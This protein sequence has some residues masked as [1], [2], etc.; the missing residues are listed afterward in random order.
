MEE[1]HYKP[2][3]A[4]FE[5]DGKAERWAQ[6]LKLGNK[7]YYDL[8]VIRSLLDST[9]LSVLRH[10]YHYRSER[11]GE[12]W[13]TRGRCKEMLADH[14]HTHYWRGAYSDTS[15]FDTEGIAALKASMEEGKAL[16]LWT[17]HSAE[18]GRPVPFP[19]KEGEV[20]VNPE[21][22]AWL[23][24]VFYGD[25]FDL[26]QNSRVSTEHPSWREVYLGGQAEG[27]PQIW[28]GIH[29]GELEVL[30]GEGLLVRPAGIVVDPYKVFAE[31]L[32]A[33]DA[34]TGTRYHACATMLPDVYPD[35]WE[36][37]RYDTAK[38]EAMANEL[39]KAEST[40]RSALNDLRCKRKES[41]AFKDI[42]GCDGI[43][44]AIGKDIAEG[45][46]ER[47]PLW[48]AAVPKGRRGRSDEQEVMLA[49]A[50]RYL[51]GDLKLPE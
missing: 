21:A 17:C 5:A 49:L 7:S 37:A 23:V 15:T 24:E 9:A 1:S 4:K 12:N 33:S 50:K 13:T 41:K 39:S 8:K 48:A 34:L 38:A 18:S 35:L 43:L 16:G 22:F 46:R 19:V 14:W 10:D 25:P 40:Y 6:G 3:P 28:L 45:L 44:P 42:G 29:T 36:G 2:K 47:A 27:K 31:T 51:E 32:L 11:G 30:P 20:R 26:T